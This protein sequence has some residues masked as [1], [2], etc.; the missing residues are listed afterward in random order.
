MMIFRLQRPLIS[1]VDPDN[2]RA[3]K[4]GNDYFI[5]RKSTCPGVIIECGF[6]SCPEETAKLVDEAYQEK[7]AEAIAESVCRLYG[8]K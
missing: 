8:M 2:N 1:E 5:L 4:E 6:L 7:L 3:A